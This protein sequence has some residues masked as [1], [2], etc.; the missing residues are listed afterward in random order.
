MF[1]SIIKLL[2]NIQFWTILGTIATIISAVVI[3]LPKKVADISY[4]FYARTDD[5]LKIFDYNIETDTVSLF[6]I[7]PY[8]NDKNHRLYRFTDIKLPFCFKSS[9]EIANDNLKITVNSS[10]QANPPMPAVDFG[11]R[12]FNHIDIYKKNDSFYFPSLNG[13]NYSNYGISNSCS[14]FIPDIRTNAYS[15]SNIYLRIYNPFLCLGLIG[16]DRAKVLQNTP[17]VFNFTLNY[18]NEQVK[19]P[20]FKVYCYIHK[21]NLEPDEFPWEKDLQKLM[22]KPIIIIRCYPLLEYDQSWTKDS[23]GN[24]GLVVAPFTYLSNIPEIIK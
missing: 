8:E 23:G 1:H 21:D 20:Y 18:D 5:G 4:L 14:E 2:K 15:F 16:D 22:D 7:V 3:F 24:E 10:C 13:P 11:N 6:F 12:N 9:N 17:I 19:S